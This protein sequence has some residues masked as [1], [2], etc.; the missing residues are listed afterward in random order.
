MVTDVPEGARPVA[1]V[2]ILDRD[3]RVLLL[4]GTNGV[5]LFW[6]APGGGVEPGETF[7][8]A[9]HRE[10]LEE[11]GLEIALG[12]CIWTRH[13]IFE[14]RG[15]QYNQFERFYIASLVRD[16]GRAHRP[17]AYVV[18]SRWWT[19]EEIATSAEIF[20]PRRLAVLWPDV[21]AG[22]YPASPFDC[23]V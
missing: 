21:V 4:Q 10:V 23:G 18:A 9:A 12:P 15:R 16:V 7:E 8:A 5:R 17:D 6:L 13:H 22:R 14:M 1:R 3:R 19:P 20:A 11:T 2:L